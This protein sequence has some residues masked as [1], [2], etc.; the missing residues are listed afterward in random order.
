EPGGD[1]LQRR[2]G[3]AAAQRLRP[4]DL[5][6]AVRGRERGEVDAAGAQ[7]LDPGAVG[8]EF[9]PGAAAHR[10]DAGLG[11]H[12]EWTLRRRERERAILAPAGEA[13]LHVEAHALCAQAAYPAAQ[14]G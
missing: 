5:E 3:M 14:E 11:S 9:R 10:Q 6:A 2:T 4:G 7:G 1:A 8:T 12:R 13:V